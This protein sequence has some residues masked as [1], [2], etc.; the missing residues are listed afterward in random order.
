M[1]DG[2]AHCPSPAVSGL[3]EG[4]FT[5]EM[6]EQ[7]DHHARYKQSRL[8]LTALGKAV[9]AQ[10]DDFARHNP[11]HRWWGGTELT[12]HRLWRWDSLN[13]ALVAP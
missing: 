4:P 1:L 3:D 5:I 13:R 6:H 12:N 11:I 8:S 2:L 10:A 9:L 7:A